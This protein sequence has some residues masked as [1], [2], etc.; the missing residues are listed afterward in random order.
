MPF[1]EV[2]MK[3]NRQ[4]Q[5]KRFGLSIMLCCSLLT[6]AVF[7]TARAQ[8]VPQYTV[9]PWPKELPNKWMI[10]N[11]TGLVVNKNDHIWVLQRP[12][13]LLANDAAAAQTPPAAEC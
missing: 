5:S 3:M 8:S 1:E 9:V 4:T 11:A 10:A 13:M 2:S 12:H 6:L 7:T